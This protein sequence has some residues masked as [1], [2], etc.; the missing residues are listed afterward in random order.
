MMKLAAA[1][2]AV[3]APAMLSAAP[4]ASKQQAELDRLL[5]GRV[6]GKPTSCILRATNQHVTAYGD[7]TLIY[8]DYDR[9]VYRNDPAGGCHGAGRD[10]ILVTRSTIG[11]VC[12]GDIVDIV[13]RTSRFPIGT[14]T[15]SDFVPYTK[16]DGSASRR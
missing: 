16:A 5:A 4:L 10:G 8:G 11:Q 7:D 15:L 6:A 3:A 9:V 2:I 13:D 12:R 1:L 14:C